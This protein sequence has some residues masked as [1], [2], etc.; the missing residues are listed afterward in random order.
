MQRACLVGSGDWL[1]K[2]ESKS[3][4]LGTGRRIYHVRDQ[5]REGWTVEAMQGV[6]VSPVHSVSPWF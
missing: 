4:R 1:V 5:Y 3:L 2:N 6:L